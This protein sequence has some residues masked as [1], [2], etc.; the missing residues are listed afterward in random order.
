M[1]RYYLEGAGDQNSTLYW[2]HPAKQN[3]NEFLEISFA[4]NTSNCLLHD[5]DML[6]FQKQ[7]AG[8]RAM[9]SFQPAIF[10]R[11]AVTFATPT[12]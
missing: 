9:T 4:V 6:S 1:K 2:L 8:Q 10:T 5:T 11:A 12:Q 3:K 7:N